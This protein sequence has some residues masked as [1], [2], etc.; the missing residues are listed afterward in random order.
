[1]VIVTHISEYYDITDDE[2]KATLMGN[3]CMVVFNIIMEIVNKP[4]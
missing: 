4:K 3:L 1:M 2:E